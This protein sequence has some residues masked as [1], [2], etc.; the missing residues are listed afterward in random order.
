MS[1][2]MTPQEASLVAGQIYG[3]AFFG[4]LAQHGV[5][6]APEQ[7]ERMLKMAA[8][9]AERNQ[10]AAV[11]QAGLADDFLSAV[12]RQL[13]IAAQPARNAYIDKVAADLATDPRVYNAILTAKLAEAN[14]AR[15]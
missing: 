5:V 11:K 2:T 14:Q 4:T 10:Q 13:G 6:P 15:S 7:Q 3:E 1:Q 8:A 12:E 9:I